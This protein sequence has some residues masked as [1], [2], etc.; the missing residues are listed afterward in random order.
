M[1]K[2]KGNVDIRKAAKEGDGRV[3]PIS[4]K[5]WEGGSEFEVPHRVWPATASAIGRTP[6]YSAPRGGMIGG[7]SVPWPMAICSETLVPFLGASVIH[8]NNFSCAT[9]TSW[10][11]ISKKP[12]S[13]IDTRP[14]LLLSTS[15]YGDTS[16]ALHYNCSTVRA[17]CGTIPGRSQLRFM[18]YILLQHCTDSLMVGK[19]P[20]I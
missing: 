14:Q 5:P 15:G 17:V 2:K 10:A 11:V 20:G 12:N 1:Q 3:A 8:R 16:T 13:Q 9:R 18:Y 7:A 4:K 19:T 6:W